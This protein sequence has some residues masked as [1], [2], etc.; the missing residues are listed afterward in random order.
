MHS[1]AAVNGVLRHGEIQLL[2]LKY[3]TNQYYN[4]YHTTAISTTSR[5]NLAAR[6]LH[7][8]QPIGV[9]LMWVRFLHLAR[10]YR[11]GGCPFSSPGCWS[12]RCLEGFQVLEEQVPTRIYSYRLSCTFACTAGISHVTSSPSGASVPGREAFFLALLVLACI[13]VL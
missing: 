12:R 5:G 13:V 2:L 6:W 8:P 1:T 10:R 3:C 7:E 9:Q 4:Y 11:P